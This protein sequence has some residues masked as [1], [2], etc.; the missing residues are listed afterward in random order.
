[1]L[2][3]YH[4][5]GMDLPAQPDLTNC[6]VIYPLSN[7]PKK[8]HAHEYIGIREHELN[9]LFRQEYQVLISKMVILNPVTFTTKKEFNLHRILRAID[10]NMLLSKLPE[11]EICLQSEYFRSPQSIVDAYRHYPQIMDNTKQILLT[12]SFDFEFATPRNKIHYTGSKE[13]DIMLL[14]RLA[15]AGMERRYGKNHEQAKQRV[16][17][18]LKV[19]DELHFSGYFLITWD[20]IRYSNSMGFMHVGRGSGANSIVA[21]CL[22]ITDICPLEL[23][24]YF[25]RF[26]NLNRKSPR[27]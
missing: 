10:K 7:I 15:Y 14:T 9:S 27:F 1:M 8:L 11:S 2:T 13:R 5:D 6:F 4:C 22:G 24:L 17:K 26:L 23:D 12:C 18:E 3:A 25:E 19:I 16:E 21:Y 20:I